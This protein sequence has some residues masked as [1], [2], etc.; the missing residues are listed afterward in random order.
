MVVCA[1]NSSSL[2]AEAEN[3]QLQSYLVYNHK[4]KSVVI[5]LIQRK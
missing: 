1:C 2:E 4:S 3:L 5:Y